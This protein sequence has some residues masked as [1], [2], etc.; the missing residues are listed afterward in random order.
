MSGSNFGLAPPVVV[1]PL[2]AQTTALDAASKVYDLRDKQAT[3]AWGN[4]L[5]QA[6]DENGNVNLQK[7]QS[8]ASQNPLARQGMAR[9]LANTSNIRGQQLEQAAKH[10]SNIGAASLTL[11]NDPSDTNLEMV[12]QKLIASGYPAEL[13]NREIDQ[14]KQMGPDQRR[15]WAY[16]HGVAAMS[17]DAALNRTAGQ[18]TMGQFG[19]T[20]A[21]QTIIQGSPYNAPQVHIG[22]GVAHTMSPGEYGAPQE[23]V[24]GYN[25]QGQPVPSNDPSAVRWEKRVVP[26]GPAMGQPAPGTVSGAPGGGSGG[27]PPTPPQTPLPT[28]YR[29]RPTAGAPGTAAPTPAPAGAPAAPAPAAPAPP[30]AQPP[31]GVPTSAPTGAEKSTEADITAYKADQAGLPDVQTS[32]Q[33]LAHA[34]TALSQ[35]RSATGKGAEGINNLRSWAQTLGIAPA[36][37]VKEQE[38]FELVRKYTER[39]MINAAGGSTTDM[40]RRMQEA[41]NAGTLLSTPANFEILRNDM[42][43]RLQ[44]I[45]AHKDH[46][47]QTGGAGYLGSRAKIADATDPRGF[48]WGLYGPDEQAKILAEVEKNPTASAKLHKA[49]GMAN[50]LNLHITGL[51]GG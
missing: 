22:G 17:P 34:Y 50:R 26:R 11:M 51:P 28:G 33:N 42:G 45:A 39:E 20:S 47:P 46:D 32:T 1:N 48:V 29:P 6:T 8:I 49:I 40:G 41:A 7:A 19:G 36:G 43:K 23:T 13:I 44:T 9:N 4:A 27:T 14:A 37:A 12:R 18:T 35:L 10:M 30:P 38:L 3:E 5:Q 21:P 2:Q 16:Q 25:A 15:Q 31:A 24:Q